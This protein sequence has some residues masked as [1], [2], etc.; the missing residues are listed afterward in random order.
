MRK[1]IE[2]SKQK[3]I[4]IKSTHNSDY[5]KVGRK[6][7]SFAKFFQDFLMSPFLGQKSL[8]E[9]MRTRCPK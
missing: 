8:S 6:R 9:R 2:R 7:L 5:S 4:K 1:V 3:N